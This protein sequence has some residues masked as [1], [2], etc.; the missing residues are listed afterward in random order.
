MEDLFLGETFIEGQAYSNANC[1]DDAYVY[2]QGLIV[3][4]CES[5]T[6]RGNHSVTATLA[7]DGPA[8][9]LLYN[10][11]EY[12]D[13]SMT[14]Y[15]LGGYTLADHLCYEGISNTGLVQYIT[16]YFVHQSY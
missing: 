3:G 6:T 14:T 2:R 15:A 13:P 1:T 10:N 12:A 9:M 11:T 7:G 5:F 4:G 8:T 16:R